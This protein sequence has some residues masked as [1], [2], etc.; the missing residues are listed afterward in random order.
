MLLDLLASKP[1]DFPASLSWEHSFREEEKIPVSTLNYSARLT[2]ISK[3]DK[4]WD[5]NS[6]DQELAVQCGVLS[7]IPRIHIKELSLVKHKAVIDCCLSQLQ[8][9]VSILLGDQFSWGGIWVW[10]TVAHGQIGVQTEAR[11]ILSSTIPWFL[12]PDGSG[13]VLLG[14]GI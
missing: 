4:G 7:L 13:W 1:Q 3:R 14:P 11:R 10:R 5:D 6:S 8:V 2:T 9:C 12:C